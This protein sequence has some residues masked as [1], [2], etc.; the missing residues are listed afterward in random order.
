MPLIDTRT[1]TECLV[2]AVT[3]DC[4]FDQYRNVAFISAIYERWPDY[5]I[6]L[7]S[8]QA[9]LQYITEQ[10][11]VAARQLSQKDPDV[12]AN[13]HVVNT[14]QFAWGKGSGKLTHID[15]QHCYEL[16]AGFQAHLN[17]LTNEERRNY[18]VR[19]FAQELGNPEL[20][21]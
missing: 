14:S 3:D 9:D 18:Y 4:R 12:F 7:Q 13:L 8:R 17:M 11:I 15:L 5:A 6:Y 1:I 21:R 2:K 16:F 10:Y 19:L 20:F